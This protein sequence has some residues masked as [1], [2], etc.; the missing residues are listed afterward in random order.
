MRKRWISGMLSVCLLLCFLVS[1][2]AA[3]Q[4]PMVPASDA[5]VLSLFFPGSA[6]EPLPDFCYTN[7]PLDPGY[8]QPNLYGNRNAYKVNEIKRFGDRLLIVVE[9]NG[10]AHSEG[11]RNLFFGVYDPARG[12]LAGDVLRF[13]GDTAAYAL[14]CRNGAPSVFCVGSATYQGYES[15]NGGRWEWNGSAWALAWPR[16]GDARSQAYSDFWADRKG[17]IG[18]ETPGSV[19]LYTRV[20][21]PGGDSVIPA[22]R[23]EYEGTADIFQ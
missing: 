8:A 6:F 3:A 7:Q 11:Y 18:Y 10:A 23:W 1:G 12:G 15:C 9:E 14:F 5:D 4:A 13:G 19:V 16:A 17:E 21:E 20:R 2:P 22:Y